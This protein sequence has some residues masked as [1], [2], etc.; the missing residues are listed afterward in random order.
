MR[1]PEVSNQLAVEVHEAARLAGKVVELRWDFDVDEWRFLRCRPDSAANSD[2]TVQRLLDIAKDEWTCKE[3]TP[4][5]RAACSKIALL[6][7]SIRGQQQPME[8]IMQ[9]LTESG[10]SWGKES[11]GE[12][13]K[14]VNKILLLLNKVGLDKFDTLSNQFLETI[15]GWRTR[16]DVLREFVLVIFNKALE[17]KHFAAI[18]TQLCLSLHKKVPKFDEIVL[19]DGKEMTQSVSFKRILLNKCQEEFEKGLTVVDLE[20]KSKEELSDLLRAKKQRASGNIQFIGELYKHN[21]VT[22]RII[23][24]CIQ[25][26]LR[27]QTDMTNS[28][29]DLEACCELLITTGKKLDVKAADRMGEYF[30]RLRSISSTT[31]LPS[32]IRVMCLDLIELR[33]N[34]WK[35]SRDDGWDDGWRDDNKTTPL[36]TLSRVPMFDLKLGLWAVTH[37]HEVLEDKNQPSQELCWNGYHNRIKQWL[38][39]GCAVQRVLELCCGRCVDFPRWQAA[40][41]SSVLGVDIDEAAVTEGRARVEGDFDNLLDIS[42]LQGDVSA[43]DWLESKPL[44]EI[45]RGFDVAFCHFAVHYLFRPQHRIRM[46]LKNAWDLLKPN[47]RFYV[48]FMDGEMAERR[49]SFEHTSS[50]GGASFQL[51]L[52]EGG[53]ADVLVSSIGRKHREPLITS[54]ELVRAFEEAGFHCLGCTNFLAFAALLDLPFKLS[55]NDTSVSSLF[56]VATFE[57]ALPLS[58]QAF[59]QRASCIAAALA[60]QLKLLVSDFLPV[61][62]LL[63]L[64]A[65]SQEW[66]E[67]VWGRGIGRYPLEDEDVRRIESTWPQTGR[68]RHRRE[69]GPSNWPPAWSILL[70]SEGVGKLKELDRCK[71]SCR[72]PSP[73][74]P[75]Y[76]NSNFGGGSDDGEYGPYDHY[77]VW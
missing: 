50:V 10:N 35:V 68:E 66:N 56:A 28:T 44:Q 2:R 4:A 13:Q 64:A 25:R 9:P 58:V 52:K 47:A 33:K 54:T 17:E 21:M 60:P 59:E 46:F 37:V 20:G 48:T 53:Q 41:I 24:T 55:A 22:G 15:M 3:G 71:A 40:M 42:I 1:H 61:I 75:S 23:H 18:Y 39:D 26:L 27:D 34:K 14:V 62:D 16:A 5:L 19:I 29:G 73:S 65:V 63:Q 7:I 72:S 57:K 31:N 51:N 32:S 8:M 49:G 69:D 38:Y 12:V 11:R 6:P 76:Y 43:A 74:P 70:N 30:N 45:K 77:Q 67:I 36:S